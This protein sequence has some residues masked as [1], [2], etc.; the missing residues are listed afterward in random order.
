MHDVWKEIN[1]RQLGA[2]IDTLER[3]INA[4]PDSIWADPNR[5][6]PIWH[7]AFHTIFWLD[8]YMDDSGSQYRPPAP[9]GLEELDPAGAMPPR[10]YTRQE[11]LTF[12]AHARAKA[13]RKLASLTA[14]ECT[15]DYSYGNTSTTVGEK[16]LYVMRHTQHHAA[17]INLMLRQAINSAP[18][19]VFRAGDE[20]NSQEGS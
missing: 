6:Q 17:Q 14:E 4:C 13:K 15:K 10:A 1:W 19:W 2:S 18:R 9:F 11:L 7:F 8:L 3:A 20:L 5:K 12:L 16:Y